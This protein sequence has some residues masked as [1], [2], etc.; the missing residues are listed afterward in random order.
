MC[1]ISHSVEFVN[2]LCPEIWNVDAG[3]LTQ[4]GKVVALDDAFDDASRPGSRTVSKAG[5][6][7]SAL[8]RVGTPGIATPADSSAATSAANS[9]AEDVADGVAKLALKPKKKKKVCCG[10]AGSQ[11]NADCTLIH[12][13]VDPK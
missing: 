8:S 13:T 4:K 2:A 1:I 10:L 5:T 3:V 12:Q 7:R 6:A 11:G 9:G